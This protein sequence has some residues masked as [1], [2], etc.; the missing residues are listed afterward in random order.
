MSQLINDTSNL[1]IEHKQSTSLYTTQYVAKLASLHI[2]YT[3]MIFTPLLMPFMISIGTTE[4][5][6]IVKLFHDGGTGKLIDSLLHNSPNSMKC[7][8]Y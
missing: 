4:I 6:S 5:Q 1:F 8:K 2:I 3:Y 7:G